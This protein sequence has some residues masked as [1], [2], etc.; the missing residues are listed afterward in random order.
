MH[1]D[2]GLQCLKEV[3]DKVC[4]ALE[5]DTCQLELSMGMSDDFEHAVSLNNNHDTMVH[6]TKIKSA[7][8]IDVYKQFL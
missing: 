5:I 4:K 3:R 2:C 6:M 7:A 1:C 8:W